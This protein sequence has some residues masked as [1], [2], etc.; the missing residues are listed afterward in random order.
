MEDK[1]FE[2]V[3]VVRVEARQ[4]DEGDYDQEFKIKL[5]VLIVT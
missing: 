4:R 5:G 2:R 1:S 3:L